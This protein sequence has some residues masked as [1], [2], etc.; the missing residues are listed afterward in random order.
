[1]FVNDAMIYFVTPTCFAVANTFYSIIFHDF[2]KFCRRRKHPKTLS[3]ETGVIMDTKQGVI[4]QSLNGF[5]IDGEETG[6]LKSQKNGHVSGDF[7][8]NGWLKD[9]DNA[10]ESAC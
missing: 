8:V 5:S 7:E 6:N 9:I 3:F 2:F 1:M 10:T 4:T